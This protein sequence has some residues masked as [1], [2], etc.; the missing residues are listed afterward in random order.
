MQK[1][2]YEEVKT[3]L[4][5]TPFVSFEADD[6]AMTFTCNQ[7]DRPIVL[8]I[9]SDVPYHEFNAD[10]KDD[11]DA[12]HEICVCSHK[13]WCEMKPEFIEIVVRLVLS[14]IRDNFFDF[15]YRYTIGQREDDTQIYKTHR[16]M[17]TAS[18]SEPLE[19]AYYVDIINNYYSVKGYVLIAGSDGEDYMVDKSYI[20][21]GLDN[22]NIFVE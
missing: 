10:Q 6:E 14:D 21:D 15:N 22:I 2:I 8:A 5:E 3:I 20:I 16:S 12:D 4:E 9:T 19:F 1:I 17:E 7:F 11:Y 18:D 13:R